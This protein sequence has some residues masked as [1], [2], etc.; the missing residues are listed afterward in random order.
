MVLNG[1]SLLFRRPARCQYEFDERGEGLPEAEDEGDEVHGL[2]DL[3]RRRRSVRQK[4]GGKTAA[5]PPLL[6][7]APFV[8]SESKVVRFEINLI[9]ALFSNFLK[10]VNIQE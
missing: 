4:I 1:R 6:R 5:R 7:G 2:E 10:L 9:I 8:V 3:R